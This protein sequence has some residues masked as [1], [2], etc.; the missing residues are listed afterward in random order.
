MFTAAP[1]VEVCEQAGAGRNLS[2]GLTAT[3]YHLKVL[4]FV[5][6]CAVERGSAGADA[7]LVDAAPRLSER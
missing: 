6:E 3:A 1:R 4:S 5:E 7:E 2:L